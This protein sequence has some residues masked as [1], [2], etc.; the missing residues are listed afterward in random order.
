MDSFEI[1]LRNWNERV[2]LHSA[3]QE[4]GLDRFRSDPEHLSD[5]VRFDVERLGPLAG[6]RVAHLQC[7]IGTDTVSLARLGAAH[8]TGLDFSPMAVEVARQLALDLRLPVDIVEADVYSAPDA[9]GP[10]RFDVVYTG[11]G[12]LCW[13]PDIDRWASVV[14]DLLAPGGR[15]FLREGH[16]VLWSLV[17]EA[18]DSL[19]IGHPYFETA[20]PIIDVEETT[21]VETEARLQNTVTH[22]WNHGLAEVITA[23][24][25]HGLTLSGITEHMSVPWIA[26]PEQMVPISGGE[27]VLKDRPARLPLT[28]TLQA[29][30]G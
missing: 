24:M 25:D 30:K 29:S 22:T 18:H 7:H 14:S 20:E 5:V 13:L 28:Y 12:A 27:W 26:L 15:L 2:P 19:V 6:Q 23:V 8:V 21:Y 10:G 17:Y 1:N 9:L 3:S 16:P 4:Y 11:I